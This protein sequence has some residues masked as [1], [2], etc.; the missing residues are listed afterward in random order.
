MTYNAFP[1]FKH[2]TPFVTLQV[3]PHP[4]SEP[5]MAGMILSLTRYCRC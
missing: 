2:W 1:V 3:D 5:T 4:V